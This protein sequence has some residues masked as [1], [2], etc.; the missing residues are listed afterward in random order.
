MGQSSWTVFIDL[1]FLL[2]CVRILYISVSRGI[3]CEII[4][5]VGLLF[6]VFFAFQYYSFIG[7]TVGKSILFLNERYFYLVAFLVIL[8]GIRAIFSFLGLIVRL[9]FKRQDITILERWVSFFAGS[10]RAAL[11]S[12]IIL[13]TLYL[14]PLSSEVFSHSLSYSLFRNFAPGSYMLIQKNFTSVNSRFEK[15]KKVEEYFNFPRQLKNYKIRRS[16]R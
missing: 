3:V 1:L 16:T 15:N 8:L 13:F 9:L 12:S 11:L 2:L 7:D 10:F 6:G 4:K 5:I 14:S